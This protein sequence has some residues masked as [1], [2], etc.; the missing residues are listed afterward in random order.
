MLCT[1]LLANIG[2]KMLAYPRLLFLIQ[3]YEFHKY[4]SQRD[5]SDAAKLLVKLLDSNIIPEL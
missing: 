3:Y 1:D 2:A 5:L 4:Y